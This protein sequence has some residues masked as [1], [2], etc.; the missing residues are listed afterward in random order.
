MFET[1]GPIAIYIALMIFMLRYP[2]QFFFTVLIGGPILF[3]YVTLE[4][5]F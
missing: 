4:P 1:I 5:L 2:Q 3:L